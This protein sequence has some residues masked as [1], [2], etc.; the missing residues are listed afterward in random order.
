MREFSATQL[1]I[2]AIAPVGK[3]DNAL[4]LQ[5]DVIF[6]DNGGFLINNFLDYI[7]S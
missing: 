2:E 7:K 1:P 4:Y 5:N 3:G 6:C